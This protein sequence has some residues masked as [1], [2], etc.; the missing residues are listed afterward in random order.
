MELLLAIAARITSINVRRLFPE[1]SLIMLML[2]GPYGIE[3]EQF[4]G[5]DDELVGATGQV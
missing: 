1:S 4:A 2:G 3:L 5:R